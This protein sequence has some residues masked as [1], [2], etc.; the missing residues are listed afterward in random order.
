V[1]ED[2]GEEPRFAGGGAN[3][4]GADSGQGQEAAEAFAVGGDKAKCLY[5]QLFC[6][7]PSA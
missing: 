1:I 5:R 4:V 6:R 7:F 3:L 2:P